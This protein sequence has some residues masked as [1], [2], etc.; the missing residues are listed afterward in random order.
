MTVGFR[1]KTFFTYIVPPAS[2]SL[3]PV[4]YQVLFEALS[5]KGIENCYDLSIN[6]IF[7][8]RDNDV[9]FQVNT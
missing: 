6:H 9:V 3:S 7:A 1:W 2:I 5:L 4:N 8:P